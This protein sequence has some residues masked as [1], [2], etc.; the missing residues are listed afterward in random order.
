MSGH[1]DGSDSSI[2]ITVAE[3]TAIINVTEAALMDCIT[4]CNLLQEHGITD[5]G[6]A[7]LRM[8]DPDMQASQSII[9]R[10]IPRIG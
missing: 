4:L 1:N 5:I 9:N 2:T 3:M 6:N 7:H 8:A 10:I